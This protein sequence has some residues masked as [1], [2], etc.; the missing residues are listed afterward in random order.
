MGRLQRAQN[1][2]T[3]RKDPLLSGV[4]GGQDRAQGQSEEAVSKAE[5]K[6]QE[7]F[8]AAPEGIFQTTKEG[9]SLA[10][11]PAGAKLLGFSSSGDAVASITD[12]AHDVWLNPEDRARYTELLEEQGEIHDFSCQFKRA[13]GTPIWVSLSA[14]RVCGQDG[15]TLYYQGFIEDLTEQRRL[16]AALRG[17]I[18]ELQILSEINNA[19][20][21]A[22]TEEDLLA[23]YCRIIVDVGGYLMAW[24]G[25]AGNSPDK[26]I[27]PVAKSG[28]ED[29][30]LKT[31]NLTWADTERGQGPTARAIRSGEVQLV[32]DVSADPAI[33]PWR[34]EALRRGYMSAIALPFYH[35]EG[36]MACLTAHGAMRRSWSESERGLMEQVALDLGFG[37]KSLRTGLAKAQVSG[38]LEREPGTDHRCDRGNRGPARPL[39]RG[40]PAQGDGSL[41]GHRGQ[42]W[43]F[44]RTDA[45]PS[46]GGQYSRPGQDWNSLRDS[47]QTRRLT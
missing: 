31:L 38:K 22:T 34:G 15:Q 29:G 5:K 8:E 18:R 27:I 6:F 11:N 36:S 20:L 45:G 47:G 2:R 10:L 37:I 40:P 16:E 44:E 46:P 28:H 32:E 1:L 12:S 25:F 30:Y 23:E 3:R 41:R 21:R 35:S 4:L 7:I 19:L 26:P 9:R 39:H 24:V 13:D 14:R 42:A 43:P 17:K 33:S